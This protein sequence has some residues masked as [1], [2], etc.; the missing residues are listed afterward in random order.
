MCKFL[1]FLTYR[2]IAKCLNYKQSLMISN[3][4]QSR[5]RERE[6]ELETERESL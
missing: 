1:T 5:D 2:A 4:I 6:R 3:S